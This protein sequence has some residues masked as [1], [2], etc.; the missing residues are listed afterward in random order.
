MH[1]ADADNLRIII[2]TIDI[3]LAHA[4]SRDTVSMIF[5]IIA[6]HRYNNSSVVS[7]VNHGLEIGRIKFQVTAC[8][9][10][11]IFGLVENHRSAIGDLGFRDGTI[12]VGDITR[13]TE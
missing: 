9:A 3:S 7:L 4:R 12:D 10:V 5:S 11:L 8:I 6:D 1:W 13:W 2:M